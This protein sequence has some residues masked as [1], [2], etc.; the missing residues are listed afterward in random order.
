MLGGDFPKRSSN[1]VTAIAGSASPAPSPSTGAGPLQVDTGS[2]GC[3]AA[4]MRR[5]RQGAPWTRRPRAGQWTAERDDHSSEPQACRLSQFGQRWLWADSATRH[6]YRRPPMPLV[7]ATSVNCIGRIAL[8]MQNRIICVRSRQ[9]STRRPNAPS[10][11]SGR[12]RAPR[13]P[14][15]WLRSVARRQA[16][17]SHADPFVAEVPAGALSRAGSAAMLPPSYSGIRVGVIA[18]LSGPCHV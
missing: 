2:R 18:L 9:G 12:S 1:P 14:D 4:R 17:I 3:E 7:L 5:D 8:R 10:R 6:L 15:S 16:G 13:L 11:R